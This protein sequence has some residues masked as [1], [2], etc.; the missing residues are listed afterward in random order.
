MKKT[1]GILGGI[2]P[3]STADF[4][5]RF[6]NLFQKSEK[7]RSNTDFPQII[8][9]SIPAPELY[10]SEQPNLEQ[11][12][13]GVKKLESFGVSFI[14]IVCNTAHLFYEELQKS[15]SIPIIDL[16]KEVEAYL[17]KSDSLSFILFGS[18]A[19]IKHNLYSSDKIVI[20]LNN[21]E[22]KKLDKAIFDFNRGE[23]EE[24]RK[25]I[26]ALAKKYSANSKI[27]V[28]CTE[29]SEILRSSNLDYI[30]TMD[31]LAKAT[32]KYYKS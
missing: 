29:I 1:I 16:R 26:L 21:E 2:G 31:I 14:S 19:I 9:N 11:Y 4:Y 7:P 27:I 20:K 10:L 32:L 22:I 30:D 23:K 5:L 3:E 6:I 12:I 17:E 13:Q 18:G 24:A 25:V 28:A 15:V 8:V